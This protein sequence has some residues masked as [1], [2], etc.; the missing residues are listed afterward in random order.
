MS[1][2]VKRDYQFDAK[3][4]IPTAAGTPASPSDRM[5]W[6]D[7]TAGKLAVRIA[8][9]TVLVPLASEIGGAGLTQEQIEDFM[10]L[11][12]QDNSVLDWTYTDNAG[13]PGS[14]VATIKPGVISNTEMAN[15][16]QSTIKG[17][18]AGA[19][20]GVSQDLTPAQVKTIL[21]LVAADISDFQAQVRAQITVTDTS[22]LNLTYV[23]GDISGAVLDSPLLGGQTKA[24]IQTDI[25]NAISGGAGAAYD[26]LIEIQNL[27]EA[28]DAADALISSGLAI[29]ARFYAAALASGAP[30]ATVTHG[31]GLTN[32]HD[33]IGRVVVSATG[34]EEQYEMVGATTNTITVTDE[35]GANIPGGRRVFITAGV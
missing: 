30:T 26:T 23:G 28:D 31:F 34:V 22:S 17:R 24:Q 32:I 9:A 10:A 21:A 20:T 16:A 6:V 27:L 4:A 35:T 11:M 33:F 13:A 29:R 7:T 19:G 12:I 2:T 18:E 15:M 25:I 3:L 5:L 1:L 8:G 14:L